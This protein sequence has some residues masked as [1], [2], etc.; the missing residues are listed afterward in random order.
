M[1]KL[2]ALTSTAKSTTVTCDSPCAPSKWLRK[3][4]DCLLPAS[5]CFHRIHSTRMR[6]SCTQEKLW[7]CGSKLPLLQLL[8]LELYK[9][10]TTDKNYSNSKPKSYWYLKRECVLPAIRKL[11]ICQ[12]LDFPRPN[13]LHSPLSKYFINTKQHCQ[14]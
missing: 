13:E 11:R 6:L 5:K 8:L 4:W 9:H 14:K 10:N 3:S 12:L 1:C 2:K 7:F